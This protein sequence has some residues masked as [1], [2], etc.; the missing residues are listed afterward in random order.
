[1]N[2]DEEDHYDLNIWVESDKTLEEFEISL[3]SVI[4]PIRVLDHAFTLGDIGASIQIPKIQP[5]IFADIP[6]LKYSFRIDVPT[7]PWNFW[8]DLDRIFAF[9]IASGL[10][11]KFSCRYLITA[12][13]TFF[14]LF[15][16]TNLPYHINTLYPPISSGELI[17]TIGKPEDCIRLSIPN[18]VEQGAAVNP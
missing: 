11:S 2:F 6:S 5:P 3:A 9:S 4:S 13:L 1:M 7:T 16:G 14:I 8:A 10:R 12:D 15:S 18:S 17:S